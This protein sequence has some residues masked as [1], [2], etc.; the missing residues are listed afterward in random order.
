M[1]RTA[2]EADWPQQSRLIEVFDNHDGTLSIFGT[3]LDHASNATAPTA[4]SSLTSPDPF[5]LAS[6]GRTLSYNDPQVGAR[7]CSPNPCG[8]GAVKDRNVELL[9]KNP[10]TP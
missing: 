1:I 7:E 10:L 4:I 9:V 6:I 2:A 5:E 8:E 3:I